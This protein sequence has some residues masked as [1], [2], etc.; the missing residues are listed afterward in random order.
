D[1]AG[2]HYQGAFVNG[3]FDGEGEY[4]DADGNLYRGIFRHGQLTGE[5]VFEGA[6]GLHYEGE[7]ADGLFQGQGTLTY[8]N[9]DRYQGA[10]AYGRAHGEGRHEFSD[11]RPP[12]EGEWRQGRFLPAMAARQAEIAASVEPLLYSQPALLEQALSAVAPGDDAINLYLLA[13]AG[14]GT[15]EVFRREVE[16]VRDMFGHWF[17]TGARHITLIN[18]RTTRDSQ[19]LATVTSVRRALARLA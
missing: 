7:F 12:Q 3:A 6:D 17:D 16:Y 14:D 1:G 13:I 5:G 4:T 9:G 2:G 10:L 18:S 11:G 15:Q 19:P 8:A